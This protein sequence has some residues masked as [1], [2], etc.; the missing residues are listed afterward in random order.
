MP[1]PQSVKELTTAKAADP[2]SYSG[3]N[4]LTSNLLGRTELS[5]FIQDQMGITE[6][7]FKGYSP[8]EQQGIMDSAKGLGYQGSMDMTG[9][10]WFGVEGLNFGTAMEG[11]GAIGGIYDTYRNV[12]G[13]GQ[14]DELF[15]KQ[16]NLYDQQIATNKYVMESDKASKEAF[17]GATKEAFKKKP[18]SGLGSI[19]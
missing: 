7:M 8:I 6:S 9:G 16:M 17:R 4:K 13:A 1:G 10:D 5:D 18:D 2:I 12:V 14:Q 19:G 11:L 3:M 15:G